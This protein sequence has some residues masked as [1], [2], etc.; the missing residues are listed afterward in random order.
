MEMEQLIR[1]FF[2]ASYKRDFS[3]FD[4]DDFF[5]TFEMFLYDN[6]NGN[7][8]LSFEEYLDWC[9]GISDKDSLRDFVF[10]TD[11]TQITVDDLFLIIIN[12]QYNKQRQ[13]LSGMFDGLLE[14][15]Q[16]IENRNELSEIDLILLVDEC[17]HAQH[18]S[19]DIIDDCN[20]HRIK[21]EV[22]A[23]MNGEA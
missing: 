3:K 17:I 20:I 2:Y 22:D 4:F 1:N 21:K 16:K 12:N 5:E 18:T 11:Y 9:E 23:V 10:D 14:L 15:K 19:G 7:A 8:Q 13:N 6:L